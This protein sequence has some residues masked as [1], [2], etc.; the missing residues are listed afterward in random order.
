MAPTEG[1]VIETVPMF[2]LAGHVGLAKS[3]IVNWA[4]EQPL[5][6]PSLLA[7]GDSEMPSGRVTVIFLAADEFAGT[8]TAMPSDELPPAAAGEAVKPN[9]GAKARP[10]QPVN[11]IAEETVLLV[12][13]VAPEVNAPLIVL[14]AQLEGLVRKKPLKPPRLRVSC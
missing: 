1:V 4:S 7:D 5:S 8:F 11:V 14:A 2:E 9:V 6:V 10:A 3:V 12:G 13:V